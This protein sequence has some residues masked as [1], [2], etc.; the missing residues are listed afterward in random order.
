MT[1]QTPVYR[2]YTRDVRQFGGLPLWLVFRCLPVLLLGSLLLLLLSIA[3]ARA[4][5]AEA[6][7]EVNVNG[8]ESGHLLLHDQVTGRYTPAIMQDSKVHFDIS[9]MI[10]T[11]RV[12]QS[13]R[14]DTNH[15]LE[16]VYAF[17]LPD[18][19]AV[20]F[21]EMEVGE[22]RIVG[23]IREKAEGAVI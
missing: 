10:A 20:R 14:N 17:P 7:A 21:M 15:Y 19:A 8:V 22:R 4:G 18:N 12:E 16:G 1:Y 11:V 23:K 9:G 5:Q 6:G 3:P 13:F 2:R